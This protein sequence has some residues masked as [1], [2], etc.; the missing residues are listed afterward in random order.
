MTCERK[1][2]PG[3]PQRGR[4]FQGQGIA[5]LGPFARL[6]GFGQFLVHA[7]TYISNFHVSKEEI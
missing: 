6:K 7:D 1:V 2:I 4:Y 3:F 5:Y